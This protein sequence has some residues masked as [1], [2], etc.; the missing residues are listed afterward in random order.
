MPASNYPYM[1]AEKYDKNLFLGL[2]VVKLSK[3]VRKV[4]YRVI[5]RERFQLFSYLYLNLQLFGRR[6]FATKYKL[7]VIN[8]S[9]CLPQ[10][11]L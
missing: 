5:K 4:Y 11:S 10:A 8:A 9:S 7:V 3:K 1:Q 2:F 6:C